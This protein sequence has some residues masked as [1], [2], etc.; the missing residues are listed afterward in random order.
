MGDY[1]MYNKKF[2]IQDAYFHKGLLYRQSVTGSINNLIVLH[3]NE[4]L[5]RFVR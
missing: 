3:K 4:L 5:R 2:V 1:G